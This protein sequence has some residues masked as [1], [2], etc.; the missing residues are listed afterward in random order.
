MNPVL[1]SLEPILKDMRFV[2][3]N[4]QRIKEIAPTLAKEELPIPDWR[5]PV[6]IEED[7]KKTIDFFMLLNS[8]NFA[9]SDFVTA[10]KFATFYKGKEWRG[11][12]GMIASLKRA[13]ENGIP[14]LNANYLTQIDRKG[15]GTIF[16]GNIEIPMLD[17]RL[18][19]FHEVGNVL[20]KKYK[21]HFYNLTEDACGYAFNNGNGIVEKLTTDFPSFND[22]SKFNDHILKFYKRAQLAVAALYGRLR[23]KGFNV[24][25]ID[26]LTVFADYQ[27]PAGLRQLDAIKYEKSLEDRILSYVPI[28]KDSREEQEI[29]ASTIY[30]CDLLVREINK[31]REDKINSLNIDY[32]IWSERAEGRKVPHHLTK[33][34]A[35]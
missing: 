21:G 9:F 27:L 8:I 17:E 29:R 16:R 35:Y 4:E 32:K 25:D 14:L 7:S 22:I 5:E 20:S 2:H 33:T 1:K 18:E 19:I 10:E 28:E 31:Y 13:L 34:I 3:I 30:A 15:L 23:K 24:K 11:S 12:F 26:N 6:F